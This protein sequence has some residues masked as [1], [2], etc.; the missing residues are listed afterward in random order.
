[1]RVARTGTAAVAAAAAAAAAVAAAAAAAARCRW[2]HFGGNGWCGPKECHLQLS[3]SGVSSTVQHT[4]GISLQ[5]PF[6]L[7]LFCMNEG[8]SFHYQRQGWPNTFDICGRMF[9]RLVGGGNSPPRTFSC[10][11]LFRRRQRYPVGRPRTWLVCA[12]YRLTC[13]HLACPHLV[14]RRHRWTCSSNGPRLA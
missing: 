9:Y 8:G 10:L 1:M 4:R 7:T 13:P 11:G 14:P 5:C 12:F 6:D 2:Y 3:A